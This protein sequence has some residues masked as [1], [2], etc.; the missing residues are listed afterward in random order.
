MLELYFV[1]YR[2]PKMMTRLARE[3]NRSAW[4]WSLIGIGAWI[5]GEFVAGF[6]VAL[7]HGI[8]MVLWGWPARSP[9]FSAL[10]YI[11]ALAGALISVTMVSRILTGKSR[12]KS[13]PSPPPPPEFQT[14]EPK[15]VE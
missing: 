6:A 4:K 3:R 12:Q 5:G 15:H 7:I 14:S 2:I 11:I 10:T 13:F 9:G 8:G 1:F